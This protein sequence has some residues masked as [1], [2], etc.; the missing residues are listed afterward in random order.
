MI[1][2]AVPLERSFSL[3]QESSAESDDQLL[4]SLWSGAKAFSWSE[5]EQ[6]FRCVLL[7]EAGAGKTFEMR[8]HAQ[9]MR[10]HGRAAFFIRIEDIDEAFEIAFEVGD[11]AGFDAWLGSTSEAWFFL[12]SVDEARLIDPRFFE[13]A[14]K[15]F[16][17]RVKVAIHRAHIFISSR[18]YAWRPVSDQRLIEQYLPLQSSSRFKFQADEPYDENSDDGYRQESKSTLKVYQLNP[19]EE[20]DIRVFAQHRHVAEIDRMLIELE[21]KDLMSLAE[22]PYDLEAI[23]VK[24]RTDQD[25]GSRLELLQCT[26]NHRLTET[27]PDRGQ[28]QTIGRQRALHGARLLAAA[29]VLTGESGIRIPD[30]GPAMSGIDAKTVLADW[31]AAE[32]ESLLNLGVFNDVIHRHVRFRH[33]EIRELLAAEWFAQHLAVG[34]TRHR[35]EALFFRNAYGHSVIAPRVRPLLPWLILFDEQ[36]KNMAM[37]VEPDIVLEGGDV[38]RL[39]YSDRKGFLHGL[40]EGIA[41]DT[42]EGSNH[43]NSAISGIAQVDL[44]EDVEN[45]ISRYHRNDRVMFFLGRL[46]WQGGMSSC[47]LKFPEVVCDAARRLS[48]R[49]ALVRAIMTCG[50]SEQKTD[51]WDGLLASSE[52]LPSGLLGEVLDGSDPTVGSVE[53]LDVAI[54]RLE[55]YKRLEFSRLGQALRRFIDRLPVT[56]STPAA[57][58]LMSF[59]TS[60]RSYIERGPF[61]DRQDSSVSKKY[62]WLLGP[63]TLAVRR[64]VAVQAKESQSADA[65]AVMRMAARAR[66]SREEDDR[67]DSIALDNSI[68]AWKDLND[69]LFWSSVEAERDRLQSKNGERLTDEWQIRWFNPYW[70]FGAERF[71]DV[72]EYVQNREI[73]DDRHVAL[74]VA[75]RIYVQSGR[76]VDWLVR[77]EQSVEASE[78]LTASLHNLINPATTYS[79]KDNEVWLAKNEARRQRKKEE[80]RRD[81]AKWVESCKD[82]PNSIRCPPNLKPSQISNSQCWLLHEVQRRAP[83]TSRAEGAEWTLLIAEFGE[84]VAQAYRDAAIDHWRHFTPGLRSEGADTSSITYQLLFAISGLAIEASEVADFPDNLSESEADHATRY[85]VW[86]INGVPS[87]LE[88][89]FKAYPT[90]VLNRVWRELRWELSN[91]SPTEQAHYVLNDLA[92][93]APWSHPSLV[94]P[95]IDWLESNEVSCWNA[96]RLCLHVVQN[97]GV[98]AAVLLQLAKSK[99]ENQSVVHHPA[100]WQAIWIDI[101]A[102]SGIPAARSWLSGLSIQDATLQ[103]QLLISDLMGTRR[104]DVSICNFG[105]FQTADYLKA[106]YLLMHRFIRVEE[107]VD[108]IGKGVYTPGLR[109]YAQDG[110]DAVL[111]KLSE[112]PGKA[113]Y[114]ALME[115]SANH[116]DP[117][118]RHWMKE[119]AIERATNDADLEVWSANQVGEFDRRRVM[120]P[121]SHRQL[122]DAGVSALLD[123]KHWLEHG[124][125]SAYVTWRRAEDESEVRNLVSNWINQVSSN[126]FTCAQEN[127]LANSQRPDIW[128]QNPEVSSPVP[129]ELKLLDMDWTGPQL[130]ERLR[131]QLAGDYLREHQSG[132]GVYLLLWQ[133]RSQ[134]KS[135][136]IGKKRVSLTGLSQTLN[137]Y[138]LSISQG[139]PHVD[140]ITVVV[141]DLTLRGKKSS[142]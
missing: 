85:L 64:M 97:G 61:I 132:C 134:R 1:D 142:T 47:L 106:L 125:D 77:L 10:E 107:N 2:T 48:T 25:L 66:F 72:L 65:L 74:S 63:A 83:G 108:Q 94:T 44:T 8:S 100:V 81:R 88:R 140:A 105:D 70:D 11:L 91:L 93:H 16:A 121:L 90:L 58:P 136:I 96:Q 127:E 21:R 73:L 27:D 43:D 79:A 82:D 60:I 33:R 128:I 54:P 141:I 101:D 52:P 37:R 111:N 6:Q 131:N 78:A 3:V 129:I 99:M 5:L 68:P 53:K 35:V 87:W 139:Y 135:W 116:P 4:H 69:A 26:I 12:D 28:H 56:V 29:V 112:L 130:C 40:V 114:L 31:T 92:Y 138:W 120:M 45:L 57:G 124:N 30:S 50:S 41:N 123:M 103:A 122:A 98:D 9:K 51:L 115:L 67:Y 118:R 104:D 76:P 102:E 39:P 15:R 17:A 109:D 80:K 38:A 133:G 34:G 110:R 32:V 75:N 19:L 49:I 24:W 117:R 20:S 86:E 89:L 46:V 59:V 13:R 119:L 137:E 36:V 42:H 62:F 113:T 126:R 71:D 84:K 55:P 95:L 23:L 22:R 18:P 14:I 7:A